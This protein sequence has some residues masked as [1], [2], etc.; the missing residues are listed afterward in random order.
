VLEQIESGTPYGA[1]GTIHTQPYVDHPGYLQPTDT[2]SYYFTDR[3]AFRTAAMIRTDVALNYAHR[4]PGSRRGEIF[5]TFHVLNL[6]NQ[7]QLFNLSG[8]AI[9]TTVL[10]EAGDP[11]RFEPFNPFT[12]APVQGTH[13]DYGGRFGEAIAAD[14]YTVPRTLRFSV[15]VRF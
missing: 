10:T 15:G 4:L 14:A 6:F 5:A 13:G 8:S 11:S 12:T 1:V 3:D 9:N 2:V 7:F